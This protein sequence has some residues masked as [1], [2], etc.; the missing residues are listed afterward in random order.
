MTT[1]PDNDEKAPVYLRSLVGEAIEVALIY[2][3]GQD[4]FNIRTSSGLSVFVTSKN[5][6]DGRLVVSVFDQR[7]FEDQ[8]KQPN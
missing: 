4:Y 2:R 1:L 6:G 5:D 3:D 8:L 7:V